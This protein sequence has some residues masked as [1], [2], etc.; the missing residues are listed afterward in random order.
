MS[1]RPIAWSCICLASLAVAPVV[2]ADGINTNPD[3]PPHRLA[4]RIDR[5]ADTINELKTRRSGRWLTEQRAAEIRALT[6]DLLA[7]ADTRTATLE[8]ALHAGW[9]KGFFIENPQGNFRL[10]FSGR[11]QVRF[12]YNHQANSPEDNDRWGFENRRV[13]LEFAGHVF[14]PRWTWE[15][16]ARFPRR[17]GGFVIRTANITRDLGHDCALTLGQFTLPFLRERLTSSKR[18][19]TCDRS[20][21]HD[22][23]DISRSQGVAFEYTGEPVRFTLAVHDGLDRGST[24]WNTEDTEWA[25]TGRIEALLLGSWKQFKDFTS[26]RGN[27]PA[28]MVGAALHTQR[29]EA[30]T[31]LALAP[32]LGNDDEAHIITWTVDAACETDGFNLFAAVVARHTRQDEV[33]D[34][35]VYGVIAQGGIFLTDTSELFAQYVWGDDDTDAP[36]LSVFS[37]GVNRYFHQHDVKWTL[38]VGYAFNGVADAW[39]SSSIGW[40]ADTPGQNGQTVL[41][42]QL[43][44]AF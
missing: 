2:R 20:L 16:T 14:D 17:G 33:E 32:E 22:A 3:A 13:F 29:D 39:A 40:R 42:S 37:V 19:L 15:V 4:Q 34:A 12:V 30:G 21:I 26:F 44:L 38:D 36:N 9:H 28:A 5:L 25:L 41:R 8:S 24:T 11:I 10:E 31:G 27:E 43:Q 6:A 35:D 23:F 18:Q 7:D 1:H